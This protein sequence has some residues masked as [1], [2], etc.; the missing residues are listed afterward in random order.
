MK[1]ILIVLLI[2]SLFVFAS[3]DVHKVANTLLH[4]TAS[5]PIKFYNAD[6][7]INLNNLIQLSSLDNASIILFAHKK[8]GSK[9]TIVNSYA[10]LKL[11]KNSIGAIY[12]KKGRTQIVFIKERLEKHGLI[13]NAKYK[14]HLLDE[15]QLNP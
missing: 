15:K 9:L 11:Y 14:K 7:K 8:Y 12:I 10:K 2:L 5:E 3:I 6:K 1:K 4:I 13:L